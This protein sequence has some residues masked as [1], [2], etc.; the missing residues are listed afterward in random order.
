VALRNTA[1]ARGFA[2]RIG[3][4]PDAAIEEETPAGAEARQRAC[5]YLNAAIRAEFN[6]PGVTFGARYDGSPVIVPDGTT[7]PPDSANAY[8]PTACPG[9]RTPHRWLPDGRSL[10]DLF[11][12]EFTVM[13]ARPEL[14]RRLADAA[15]RLR[16][17]TTVLDMPD[18]ETRDL[19]GAD[20]VLIRP[21]Q[22]V[23]WRGKDAPDDPASLW[24]TVTGANGKMQQAVATGE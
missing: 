18:E 23:A 14:G 13:G 10:F 1:F 12:F 8:T 21:D 24:R 17:P 15:A 4:A 7:P 9:G 2:A 22:I 19:Y 16:I 20:L 5:D 11:G 6:I 3:V